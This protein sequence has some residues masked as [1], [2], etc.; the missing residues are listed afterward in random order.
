MIADK[1]LAKLPKGLSAM[2]GRAS[3]GDLALVWSLL[4]W[5]RTIA[6]L[7]D[8]IGHRP[9][10][11]DPGSALISAAADLVAAEPGAADWV[12]T[13]LQRWCRGI[14][15]GARGAVLTRGLTLLSG[16]PDMPPGLLAALAKGD[17][18]AAAAALCDGD[19]KG[20]TLKAA[21]Q[22]LDLA[23]PPQS[24]RA[25]LRLYLAGR[26]WRRTP[27]SYPAL[28]PLWQDRAVALPEPNKADLIIWAN[29]RDPARTSDEQAETGTGKGKAATH[30]L[31]SEEPLW[32][33]IF[34]PDPLARRI[35]V[36]GPYSTALVLH[37][38]NHHRSPVFA[39]D[40]IPYYLLTSSDYASRYAAC[41]AR[42]ARLCPADWKAA[43]A[44]RQRALI[45]MAERRPEAFHDMV[46]PEG[47]L[48]GL[49]AWRTL[50]AEACAKG[51]LVKGTECV[52]V[53]WGNG[54]SRFVVDDWHQDKLNRLDG[55][56]RI[57]SAIENTHQPDYI[58]E[59]I[60]DAFACGA[61]PLYTA[62]PGHRLHDLGLPPES[63]VNLWDM[64]TAAAAREIADLTWDDGFF[65]AYAVAQ[66]QLAR[67]WTDPSIIVAERGRIGR[68]LVAELDR[69]ADLG[70]A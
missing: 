9:Q 31:F 70:P 65:A 16:R 41:F 12:A 51:D 66:V 25:R 45:F 8:P 32:D 24:G 49:C 39:F 27:F 13:H 57:L 26:H 21:N 56:V 61:R 60:F 2:E 23:T 18:T 6:I 54:E 14:A 53:S 59:K 4:G 69:L 46:R 28:A 47:D 44:A 19:Q 58:S 64:E 17:R 50:L 38:V 37:Q 5:A 67:L 7:D 40:R 42:N 36:P 52:G 35:S 3:H 30:V 15:P 11:P 34:G 63:W 20:N 43:F 33:T 22:R 29:P 1:L 62:S 55:Q 68:A 10:P 48:I